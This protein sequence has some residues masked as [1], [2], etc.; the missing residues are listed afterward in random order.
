MA[1]SKG[2]N[3]HTKESKL[4]MRNAKFVEEAVHRS[5]ALG[6]N[7]KEWKLEMRNSKFG[8]ARCGERGR[9]SVASDFK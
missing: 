2:K 1:D 4:E 6:A 9:E 5:T 3:T 8:C 7:H